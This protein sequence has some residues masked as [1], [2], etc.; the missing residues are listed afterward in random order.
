MLRELSRRDE[1]KEAGR[2][3]R[4]EVEVTLT[5]W[6]CM[7][8]Y[9]GP[10]FRQASSSSSSLAMAKRRKNRTHL[11]GGTASSG[12]ATVDPTVPKSF[13]IRHGQ[14]GSSLTQLVRDMRRLMEPHTASRLKVCVLL[15]IY[16]LA[17][18]L[19][20]QS[21]GEITQQAPRLFVYR[22]GSGRL[23]SPGVHPGTGCACT[24]PRSTAGR[25]ITHLP[26]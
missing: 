23:A 8:G 16:M 24:A 15:L 18:E 3:G 1:R 2:L 22:T 10:K 4:W 6:R 26:D 20:L 12:A 13:V 14:V 17:T 25:S 11:K 7:A 9:S 19:V 5:V 21:K